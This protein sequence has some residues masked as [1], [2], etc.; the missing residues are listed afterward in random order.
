M[1]LDGRFN[2]WPPAPPQMVVACSTD[3]HVFLRL[4]LTGPPVNLQGLEQ[5]RTL[6]LDWDG[7]PRTG[8]G[9]GYDIALV[10]SP[11]AQKGRGIS[12]GPVHQPDAPW[13]ALGLVFAPT[14][15]ATAFELRLPR[16]LM[17]EGDALA[18]ADTINWSF[19]G[20]QG[21][22]STSPR[23][24][25][26]SPTS[27]NPLPPPADGD[28]RVVAWNLEFGNIL[29]QHERVTRLL[30]AMQPHVVLLQEVES[31]QRA[32]DVLTVLRRAMPADNWTLRLGP[33][34]GR[35]RSGI[36]TRLP[37]WDVPTLTK[38]SRA[39]APRST[40]RTAALVVQGPGDRPTLCISAHLKCCGVIGGPEDLKRV[41]EV[42]AIR[43]AIDASMD[44]PSLPSIEAIV[45]GGDLNL[46]GSTL[47]LDLLIRDG[48]SVVGG[49][50]DFIIANALQPDGLSAHTWQKPNQAFSPGRLDWLVYG[51]DG[52]TARRSVV[53]DTLDLNPDQLKATQLQ[54]DD[55]AMASDHLPLLV[56][57]GLTTTSATTPAP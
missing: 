8:N 2:D 16:T 34:S 53:L 22:A 55:T 14:T 12:C 48:Q 54:A 5:P 35:L 33:N 46:V 10:F 57:L 24:L 18:V 17:M 27:G 56:D 25:A 15:A 13:N 31:N 38:L 51:G 43:R 52:L 39:D 42:Q 45:I 32:A 26:A 11:A 47:P 44:D 40:V 6:A 41:G 36:A 28:M 19:D 7:N 29:H 21:T 37:A 20:V 9:E 1:L 4:T 3:E 50:G 49:Q 30:R 23:Q